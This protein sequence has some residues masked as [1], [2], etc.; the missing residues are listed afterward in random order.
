MS[1]WWLAP[2][3]GS[4]WHPAPS[5]STARRCASRSERAGGCRRSR[6]RSAG[7]PA[8][9]AA[10]AF[11]AVPAIRARRVAAGSIARQGAK[12][13]MGAGRGMMSRM[14]VAIEVALAVVLVVGS[15]LMLR[16]L[17]K[18]NSVDPGF[19]AA[20]VL[21]FRRNPAA[22]SRRPIART[23]PPSSSSTGRSPSSIGRAPTPSAKRFDSTRSMV[24]R[25]A[26]SALSA[27]SASVPSTRHRNRKC[28]CHTR[29]YHAWRDLGCNA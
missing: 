22:R 28:T 16:T 27:M 15:G 29:S 2:R 4:D 19:Q 3:S 9:A 18:L 14:L 20:G 11:G 26:S 8:C 7:T 17:D 5:G 12:G 13:G 25:G 6:R 1:S 23:R 24:K 10:L 21:V